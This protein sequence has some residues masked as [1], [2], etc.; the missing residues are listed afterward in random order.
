MFYSILFKDTTLGV[1]YLLKLKQVKLTTIPFL[2]HQARE[3]AHQ[4]MYTQLRAP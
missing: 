3:R 2:Y 4:A 1:G